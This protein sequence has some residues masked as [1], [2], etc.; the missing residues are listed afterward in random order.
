MS[1]TIEPATDLDAR[2]IA[3]VHVL[4]WQHAY[5]DLLPADYLAGLSV[6]WRETVW[7]DAIAL[8]EPQVLVARLVGEVIG[9][10]SFGRSRDADAPAGCAELWAI[11][12]SLTAWSRGIGRALWQ[13]ARDA[14]AA[15]GFGS[16]T[17]WV[18][19]GNA[20]AIRFYEAAGF[21]LDADSAKRFEIGGQ[22]LVEVRYRFTAMP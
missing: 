18:M 21:V 12:L 20:R 3:Q 1:A 2:A 7:R 19:E 4:A 14:L 8:G 9:F 16:V 11:Y 15:Q 22:P 6:D 10:A 17:L 13:A 5:R